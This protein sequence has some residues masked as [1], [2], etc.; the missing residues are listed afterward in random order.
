MPISGNYP[1]VYLSNG[2]VPQN[3]IDKKRNE[4]YMNFYG[5]S[6]IYIYENP[7]LEKKKQNKK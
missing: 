6:S 5:D 4:F 1:P 2:Y 7:N 3:R